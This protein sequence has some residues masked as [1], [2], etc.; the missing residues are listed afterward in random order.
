MNHHAQAPRRNAHPSRASRTTREDLAQIV[1]AYLRRECYRCSPEYQLG[2]IDLLC[3]RV[4][5]TGVIGRFEKGT[6]QFDA[7]AAGIEHGYTIW[8]EI[9]RKGGF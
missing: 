4:F 5:G 3:L 6:V 1:E 7:Y 9:K 2:M 8:E